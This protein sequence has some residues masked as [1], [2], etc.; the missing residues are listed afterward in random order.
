[1]ARCQDDSGVFR[2]M[3][4]SRQARGI[5]MQPPWPPPP[6]HLTPL[7]AFPSFSCFS[8]RKAVHARAAA[9]S[10]SSS[11]GLVSIMQLPITS[12][13]QGTDAGEHR[14]GRT[15]CCYCCG[16][17]T[18]PCHQGPLAPPTRAAPG[19]SLWLTRTCVTQTQW[20]WGRSAAPE[21]GGEEAHNEVT[22]LHMR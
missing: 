8:P 11:N 13:G 10:Q 12:L 22:T 3:L 17:L 1:M 20:V 7:A 19:E 16:S 6:P 5:D 18:L 15:R 14:R 4:N 21:S 9:S 2:A